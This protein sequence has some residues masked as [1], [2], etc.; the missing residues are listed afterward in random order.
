MSRQKQTQS[1]MDNYG[2]SMDTATLSMDRM[3][4]PLRGVRHV[5]HPR[6]CFAVVHPAQG[7]RWTEAQRV[8]PGGWPT[9]GAQSPDASLP[10]EN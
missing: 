1:R 9:R 2:L 5:H 4:T 3:D 8:P 6:S 7:N 10:E